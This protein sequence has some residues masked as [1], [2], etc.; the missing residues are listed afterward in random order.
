MADGKYKGRLTISKVI[1]SD[2]EDYIMIEIE[3]IEGH[4]NIRADVSLEEF[5]QAVTGLGSRPIDLVV[6]GSDHLGKKM[7]VKDEEIP[8]DPYG[9]SDDGLREVLKSYEVDG[10]KGDI[11]D[12]KN[13]HRRVAKR[14]EEV[15]KGKEETYR[16]SFVRWV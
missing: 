3:E 13:F 7:E 14:R 9:V 1:C 12:F 15:M 16:V 10:W 5:A 4:A 2:R 8:C 11:S 6:R